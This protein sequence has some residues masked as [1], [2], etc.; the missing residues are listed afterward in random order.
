MS[1]IGGEGLAAHAPFPG[2]S[3]PSGMSTFAHWIKSELKA[4]DR[5]PAD[6]PECVFDDIATTIR[7]AGRRA[8]VAGL[9]AAVKACQIRP[10]PVAPA[11]ARRILAECL[12]AIPTPED[13]GGPLTAAQAAK[14]L[15]VS[16]RQ[17]YALC[18]RGELRHTKK[19]IR[20]PA[21]AIAEYQRDGMKA[22][23]P[24]KL[25]HLR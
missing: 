12:A 19:P 13:D 4:I 21:D 20:I 24:I 16:T 8:A 6:P 17:V 22:K 14:R 10:G 2:K 3:Y 25:R 18:E 7:E 23:Q 1:I 15:N 5:L 9:P 11:L